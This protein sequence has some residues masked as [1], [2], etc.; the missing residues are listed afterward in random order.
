M[1]SILNLLPLTCSQVNCKADALL[2]TAV[3]VLLYGC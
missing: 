3:H 2:V 1:Y